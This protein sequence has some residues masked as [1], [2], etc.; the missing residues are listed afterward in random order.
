HGELQYVTITP[1]ADP[2]G[3]NWRIV[4]VIPQSYFT[5]TIQDNIRTTAVF[6]LVTLGIAIALG[7]VAANQITAH[8]IQFNRVSQ[9]LAAGQ[10]DQRL[11][12]DQPI[13]ELNTLAQTFN[14]MADRLQH[15]FQRIQ[16]ALRESEEK[17]TTIFRT[18]PDPIAIASLAD[19]RILE[20]NDSLL[21]FFGYSQSEMIGRTALE[22]NLWNN[23]DER[24]LY[25][26]GLRQQ[27]YVRNLEVQLCTQSGDVKTV[28]LS[29]KVR[30][31]EGQEHL[32]VM[33]RDISDRKAAERE[34]QQSEARYRAIVEDQ[35]EL[36]SR[37]L[38]DTTLLFIN[39]AYCRYFGINREEVIGKSYTPMIYEADRERVAQLLQS[40]SLDN[41]TV[42]IENRVVVNGEIRW[43]QWV[44]RLLLDLQGNVIE[45]QSVGRDIT[46]LKQIEA[47]LRRSEANLLYAQHIAHVGSWKVNLETQENI[48]SEEFF[49][50]LGLDAAQSE[51]SYA[52][53][54]KLVPAEDRNAVAAA[55]QGSL[56]R[57]T[58]YEVEHRIC[59]RDG[60]V[61]YVISK[62]RAVLNNQQQVLKLHATLLDITDRKLFELALQSSEAKLK[63]LL[64]S[65]NASIASFRL[66]ADGHWEYEYW[67]EG[68]EMVFGYTAEE[69]LA[70]PMLWFSQVFPDDIEQ[71]R[72]VNLESLM[73]DC[74]ITAQGEYRFFHKDGSLRWSSFQITSRPD[75]TCEWAV[76]VIDVDV[77][78]RKQLEQSLR[79]QAEEERLLAIITQNI[80]QSL[81]LE[82]ILATTVAEVQQTLKVDR[83]LIF[84]LNPDGSGQVIQDAVVPDYPVPDQM[85]WQAEH[86]STDCYAYYQ[87]G[88]PQ[89]VPDVT[90]NAGAGCLVEFMQT[91]GVK[92]QVVAP[93]VQAVGAASTRV[94]GLLVVHVCSDC[95][96]WRGSEAD[97][98]QKICNQ[99]AIAIDQANLYQQLQAK[100]AEHQ[101]AE[102]ALRQSEA[103]LAMAQRVAQ[104]GYWEF[105]LESQKCT[106]S[107]VMF[108][109]WGLDPTQPEPSFAE[110]QQRVHPDD[111]NVFQQNIDAAL[112]QGVPYLLDLRVVHPDGAIRYLDSRAEPLFSRQGQVVK[113]IGTSLDITD[114][115]QTEKALQE[116][117]V[118]LRAIGDNLPKGF[119][120]Q[121]VYEPGKGSYYS[122]VSA[123]VERLLNL[124]PEA[125]L[126]DPQVTRTVG[127][128]EDLAQADRIAQESLKNL[129][130]IE[131]QMRNRTATGEIQWSSIRSTP[132]RLDDG[133]TVWDGVEV[134]ITDIKRI[135]VALRTSEEQFRKAFENAP[136]GVSLVDP[137]GHFVKVNPR[138]CHLLGYTEA[139]LLALNFRDI[140]HPADVEGDLGGFE[141][142]MA[143]ELRFYQGE[144]RYIDKQ[145]TVI[146]VLINA[147]PILDQEGKPLYCVGHVQD[148]RDRLK[149]ERMKNEFISVV[150]HELR[151]PLTSIQG[152][153]D[154]L[155]SGIYNN[156][157]KKA[158]H[159]LKIAI[160]N[161]DRLVRLVNDILTLERLES[162]KVQLVMEQ[163]QVADVMQQSVEGIQAIA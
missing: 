52:E 116:R 82:Q 162:G 140:T 77:T 76:T 55:F 40:M 36:I 16:I 108:R 95:R 18:S 17:F 125:I 4:T 114:R 43:T 99:L 58:P 47:A 81:D 70:E 62:G 30:I 130:P 10:L 57:G 128:E 97:F 118:M 139:E 37:F 152:A 2:D 157:P 143:G 51:P 148:M 38:P 102:E 147:A 110:L 3:L 105:N 5:E 138:Y 135:E 92:S 80:R 78:N 22:L 113:L 119:I 89:I 46:Q 136:I 7:L 159:M 137:T 50:I 103:R 84:R 121:R 42:I 94:W 63:N 11:P 26:S 64:S 23:L 60:S 12:T 141:Q 90:T 32:M 69:F 156:R 106:W 151:T 48:W 101:Q 61:R 126:A 87:Q 132:R 158:E 154:L 149:V 15:S 75:G 27:G 161:S 9:E 28:L 39:D 96:Q 56:N 129:T 122:Y 49:R 21:E 71:G 20:V 41:P 115:K 59:R 8:L 72:V 104:V 88:T 54:I 146:P 74:P 24:R 45:I 117:E 67:S 153:L 68:C 107:T 79:S 109:H 66:F 31:L 35:T 120:Y 91:V 142:M 86:F 163:C 53:F 131:L 144:K 123:G 134:D 1:Y 34:L 112:T 85:G 124:K 93:I 73:A 83:A 133:R 160:N 127:F 25:R 33:Y 19:G 14:Q 150:S 111:R 155:G 6:C 100:L 98:L 29:A 44:N 65:A 13:Y 145:G